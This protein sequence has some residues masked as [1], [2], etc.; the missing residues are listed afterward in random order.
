MRSGLQVLYASGVS[1]VWDPC[2]QI[3]LGDSGDLEDKVTVWTPNPAP[4]HVQLG[5]GAL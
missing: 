4:F 1:V 3:H 2:D 5:S